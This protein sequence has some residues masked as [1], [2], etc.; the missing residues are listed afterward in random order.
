MSNKIETQCV[1]SEKK[2][3][4]SY[5]GIKEWVNKPRF[6]KLGGTWLT[7][8]KELMYQ[9]GWTNFLWTSLDLKNVYSCMSNELVKY[10]HWMLI[11]QSKFIARSTPPILH[12]TSKQ[13]WKAQKIA[14][15]H[16]YGEDNPKTIM[17]RICNI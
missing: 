5:R 9:K 7:I 2:A 14:S 10:Q 17:N 12:A 1:V 4:I 3:A 11:K 8:Y 6:F 16:L 13:V 15:W